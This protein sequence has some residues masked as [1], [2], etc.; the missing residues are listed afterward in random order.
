ML[1]HLAP[2][3]QFSTGT[4]SFWD[5]F[6]LCSLMYESLHIGSLLFSLLILICIHQRS[7]P[8]NVP[9]LP[10]TPLGFH[11]CLPLI[12][13]FY[14][15]G[16]SYFTAF[17]GQVCPSFRA[18]RVP[19]PSGC[20]YWLPACETHIHPTCTSSPWLC[21]AV[22]LRQPAFPGAVALCSSHLYS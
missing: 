21:T 18:A 15:L 9:T 7:S 6:K 2:V 20:C 17:P 12:I 8:S 1:Y 13:R 4:H 16:M 14:W 10:Q 22:F 11:A 19:L 3:E 5:K